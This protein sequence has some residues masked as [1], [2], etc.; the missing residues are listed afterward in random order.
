MKISKWEFAILLLLAAFLAFTAG[1]F[2]RE[3]SMPGPLV[4]ETQRRP[5]APEVWLDPPTPTPAEKQETMI[6]INT[7]DVETLMTLPGIGEKRARDIITEREENG[8]FRFPED[9]TRVSGIG[10]ETL[11]GLVDYSITEDEP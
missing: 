9:I 6:N 11:A 2:L 3:R 7:A 5:D 8:P 4:V 1:W 10:E